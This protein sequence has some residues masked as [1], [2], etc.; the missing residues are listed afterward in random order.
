VG[1][2][3][4]LAPA[5]VTATNFE[6]RVSLQATHERDHAL[7]FTNSTIGVFCAI[8]NTS[9]SQIDITDSSPPISYTL[10]TLPP[11]SVTLTAKRVGNK[12]ELTWP[13]DGVLE[14]RTSLSTGNWAP[15]P[16]AVSGLQID[17]ATAVAGFYRVRQ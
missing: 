12:I 6:L 14:T 10:A 13:G 7:A 1:G 15:V 5:E 9:W 3:L 17:P 8:R 11:M 2:D 4:A 16:G